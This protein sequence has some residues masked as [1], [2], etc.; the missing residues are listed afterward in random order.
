M[1]TKLIGSQEK[2]TET[3]KQSKQKTYNKMAD[4]SPSISIILLH[5]NNLNTPIMR[6]RLAESIKEHNPTY[7]A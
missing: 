1:F 6:Q 5:V 2:K 3:Q 7:V 4:L